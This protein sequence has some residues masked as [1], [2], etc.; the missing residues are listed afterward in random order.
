MLE[1]IANDF[2]LRRGIK[3]QLQKLAFLHITFQQADLCRNRAAGNGIQPFDKQGNIL[4]SQYCRKSPT[5]AVH[6]QVGQQLFR[7]LFSADALNFRQRE[8]WNRTQMLQER[9]VAIF[10][11]DCCHKIADVLEF[12]HLLFPLQ[13][14]AAHQQGQAVNGNTPHKN[15][16]TFLVFL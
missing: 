12:T 15:S 4:H 2:H 13:P 3:I 9:T 5:L 11:Y 1:I 7:C 14:G 10:I 6:Q 8:T 16:S